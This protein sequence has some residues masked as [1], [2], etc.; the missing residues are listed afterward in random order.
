MVSQRRFDI[1]LYIVTPLRNEKERTQMTLI[2]TSYAGLSA[3]ERAGT[4]PD[5]PAFVLLHGLTFDRRMWRPILELLPASHRAIAFD[6]PAH[7]GSVPLA[8]RGLAPV[9]D[10]VHAAV[11]AAGIADPIV[12]G[13]SIGGPIA[14][15]YAAAHPA[16]GV[17]SVEAPIRFEPLAAM[18]RAAAPQL[19]GPGF[20]A[21]WSRLRDTWGMDQVAQ[22]HRELLR[23]AERAS[24][25]VVLHYQADILERPLE[26]VTR[27]RDEGMAA[28][29]AAGIP[30]ICLLAN[31][32]EPAD[33]AWLVERVP[34][35]HV[36]VWPVRHHF[37]H[38]AR[39]GLFAQLLAEVA[40]RV[41]AAA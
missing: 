12:V 27:W 17:V 40:G 19:A 25:D 30:Y 1:V 18:L 33:E 8:G 24:R 35:A 20:D 16:A 14:G 38:L 7:G 6:L 39:P 2:E 9:A 22:P 28:V 10:A 23:V 32:V 41:P 29:A 5:A 11:D 26:E 13:H 3:T 37:P 36:V 34:V 21:V 15:I 31:P 4:D